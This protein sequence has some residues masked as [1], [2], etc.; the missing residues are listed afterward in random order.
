MPGTPQTEAQRSEEGRKRRTTAK[1]AFQSMWIAG[2]T[3]AFFTALTRNLPDHVRGLRQSPDLLNALDLFLRYGYLLWL[4]AYFFTSNLRNSPTSEPRSR[5]VPFDVLQSACA[6]AAAFGLGFIVQG[7]GF[8]ADSY[9]WAMGMA[10]A[11][12][13]VISLFSW[14]WFHSVKPTEMNR[15]RII[16]G[17]ISAISLGVALAKL[18]RLPSLLLFLF[19]Q[20][21]LWVTLCFFIGKRLK[22]QP[23]EST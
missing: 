16:G 17:V 11:A 23:S 1:K 19:L 5:E 13:L 12:I 3:G 4:L 8:H 22:P 9:G 15:H 18:P 6:L 10:N 20:L 21:A 7:E 14:I 2:T